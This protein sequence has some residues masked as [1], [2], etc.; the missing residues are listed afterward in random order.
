VVVR[1]TPEGEVFVVRGG[2]SR[3]TII[4]PEQIAACVKAMLEFGGASSDR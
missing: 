2:G 3:R 1:Q 4:V